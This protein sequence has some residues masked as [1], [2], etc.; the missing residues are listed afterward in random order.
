[1][2]KKLSSLERKLKQYFCSLR[3]FFFCLTKKLSWIV[4]KITIY[5]IININN[6][7][8]IHHIH[9]FE[10]VFSHQSKTI[11]FFWFHKFLFY[12]LNFEFNSSNASNIFHSTKHLYI[13]YD[14][15]SQQHF[16]LHHLLFLCSLLSSTSTKYIFSFNPTIFLIATPLVSSFILPRTN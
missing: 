7:E 16:Y 11:Q 14:L 9:C 6:Q 4:I 10:Y 8:L 3:I 13:Q 15:L 12:D 2:K 5:F 1:M